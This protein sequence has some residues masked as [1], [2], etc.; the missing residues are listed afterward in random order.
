MNRLTERN[1]VVYAIKPADHNSAGVDGDS[2]NMGLLKRVAIAL[3]FGALTGNSVL[4]VY[5]GASAGTKTTALTFRYRLSGADQAAAGA[6]QFGDFATSAALTLT[7]ATYDNRVVVVEVDSAEMTDGE[8][9]L[10]VEIDSTASQLFVAGVAIGEPRYEAN[11]P[12]TV[13]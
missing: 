7:A 4:T 11:D 10:T 2:I 9:W 13:I 1:S 5:S 6:D 3:Q 8:E 12:P